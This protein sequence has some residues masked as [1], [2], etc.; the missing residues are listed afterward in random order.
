ML[1][2][3]LVKDE[4]T[5]SFEISAQPGEGW[6]ARESLNGQVSEEHLLHDWHRVERMAERFR[7]DAETLVGAGWVEVDHSDW[8][9]VGARLS[10]G[11]TEP[12]EVVT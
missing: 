2:I 3:T 9:R 6:I 5:R 10:H 4:H 11:K 12:R 8:S 1:N 7:R